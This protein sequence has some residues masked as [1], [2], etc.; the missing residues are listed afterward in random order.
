VPQNLVSKNHLHKIRYTPP[1]GV[2][3]YSDLYSIP[4]YIKQICERAK[5]IT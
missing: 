5:R 3:E 4:E 1:A 2:P